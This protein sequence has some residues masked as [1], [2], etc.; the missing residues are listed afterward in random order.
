MGRE[1]SSLFGEDSAQELDG[2]AGPSL[3]CSIE[4]GRN[5]FGAEMADVVG[6]G[7]EYALGSRDEAHRRGT[8]DA[9]GVEHVEAGSL[10]ANDMRC[11]YSCSLCRG[12]ISLR[13]IEDAAGLA[14]GAPESASAGRRACDHRPHTKGGDQL[15]E[16]G[17]CKDDDVGTI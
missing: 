14:M 3:S 15:D 11:E 2:L 9:L 13:G 5:A 6:V 16:T 17:G 10:A 7:V 1:R 12:T 8:H 4:V